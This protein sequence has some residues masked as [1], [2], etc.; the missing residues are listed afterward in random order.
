MLVESS[1]SNKCQVALF[2]ALAAVFAVRLLSTGLALGIFVIEHARSFLRCFALTIILAAHVDH[3]QECFTISAWTKSSFGVAAVVAAIAHVN[4]T[5]HD[6]LILSLSKT[7]F[8]QRI[9]S[10]DGASPAESA[11]VRLGCFSRKLGS[12][13]I[14]LGA[15][16]SV[17]NN[18]TENCSDDGVAVIWFVVVVLLLGLSRLIGS[19]RLICR[20]RSVRSCRDV[21]TISCGSYGFSSSS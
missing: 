6:A 10:S 9:V 17:G 12:L 20:R 21:D 4:M 19:S 14:A 11:E 15:E 8:S 13:F 2:L 1:S 5:I 18:V 3:S 16:R 7:S